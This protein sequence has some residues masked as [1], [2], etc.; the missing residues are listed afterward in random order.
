MIIEREVMVIERESSPPPY[1]MPTPQPDEPSE[2]SSYFVVPERTREILFVDDC[3]FTFS[4]ISRVFRDLR[5]RQA[6]IVRHNRPP[7]PESM[8]PLPTIL[9]YG[10]A[11]SR[12]AGLL[13][14]GGHM[15]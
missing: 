12:R 2:D 3:L 7:G 4:P 14:K 11:R 15:G 1:S 6:S 5:Q 9:K 13:K 8:I 10:T